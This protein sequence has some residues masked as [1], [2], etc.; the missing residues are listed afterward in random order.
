MSKYIIRLDDAC[1][2]MDVE[3][4]DRMENLL[5]KYNVKPLVGVIPNCQDI[6]MQKY[7][8]DNNF[9]DKVKKWQAKGWVIA[10]HGYNHVYVTNC[11]GLN[12]IN[13]KSEFAGVPLEEQKKKIR[14]G[15][16]IFKSH[17]VKTKVFFAPSHTY[18]KNTLTAL[19]EESEIR[20]ISDT[21]ANKPYTKYGFTFV[22]L[23]LWAF[24]KDKFDCTTCC[25]HP[26]TMGD[27]G[28]NVLESFLQENAKNFIVFPTEETKRRLSFR[29]R[30]C[31]FKNFVNKKLKY[32]IAKLFR[33]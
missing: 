24:A 12:P 19:K 22:P 28:F 1:E 23:Q 14:E 21:V 9:W 27:S 31:I 16:K 2:K 17:G 5:D 7:A 15:I 18:D 8:V 4:W 33:R 3:Q 32:K 13:H 10:L 11:G 20:I 30:W 26:N 29:D 6:K 25:F